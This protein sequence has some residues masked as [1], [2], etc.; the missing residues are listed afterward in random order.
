MDTQQLINYEAAIQFAMGDVLR[1]LA[2]LMQYSELGQPP[3]PTTYTQTLQHL[4]VFQKH[5]GALEQE[6]LIVCGPVWEH[7]NAIG[8]G[9][10]S[11][12]DDEN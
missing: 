6:V 10:I 2:I 12:S 8:E 4:R 1:D 5:L 9:V 7:A 11:P 3:D